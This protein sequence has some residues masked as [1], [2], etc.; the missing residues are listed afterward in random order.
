MTEYLGLVADVGGTNIRLALVNAAT[1]KTEQL[2]TYL[3]ADYPEIV[4]VIR[5]Y[6]TDVSLTVKHAVIAIACPTEQDW[7]EM[8]N[9]SWKFSKQALKAQLELEQ[10]HVINDYTAI[11]QALPALDDSQL[12]KLGG[13]EVEPFAPKAVLGPGTGLGV[14]HLAYAGERWVSFPGEGGHVDFAPS[15]EL[16]IDLLKMFI[17]KYGH[18]SYERFLCGQGLVDIYTALCLLEEVEP[19]L[20]EPKD[21]TQRAVDASCEYC[22]RAFELLC[23]ILGSHAGNLALNFAATGGVYVAGGIL[24]RFVE[25]L[26]NSD[27]RK[28]FEAK[29]RFVNYV[30]QIPCFLITEPQPG[31][32]GAAAYLKANR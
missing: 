25:L 5:Q 14:A 22:Q 17:E 19:E 24:P 16:E 20:L 6:E 30:S 13:G 3:C 8:T 12:V 18:V 4:D 31:L 28:R 9:H 1:G 21:V 23:R 27:F 10:L 2:R 15:N 11:S 7:I 32:V 26:K 29:G